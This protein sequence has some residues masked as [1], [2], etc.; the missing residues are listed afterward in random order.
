MST[1]TNNYKLIKPAL[2]DPADITAFNSNWD[3]VDSE[4]KSN[5]NQI[6]NIDTNLSN[7]QS[8]ITYGTS[9]PSGG[10]SGD[11]YIQLLV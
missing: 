2:T 11:V 9:A 8:K 6:N 10:K 5:A 7:V 4:L 3:T 1:T